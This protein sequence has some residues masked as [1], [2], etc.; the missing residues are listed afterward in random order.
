MAA[1]DGLNADQ[2]ALRNVADDLE[3]IVVNITRYLEIVK[4]RKE[5][6]N[7]LAP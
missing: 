4:E 6:Q 2:I 3:K 1:Y 7:S 5:V